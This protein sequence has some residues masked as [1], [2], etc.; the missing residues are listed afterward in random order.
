MADRSDVG[1][2][3]VVRSL[4]DFRYLS[5]MQDELKLLGSRGASQEDKD[6]VRVIAFTYQ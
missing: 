6:V 5:V 2:C 1:R 3:I 4:L